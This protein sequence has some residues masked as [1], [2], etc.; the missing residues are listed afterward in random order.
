MK[1]AYCGQ[2]LARK[3]TVLHRRSRLAPMA[4]SFTVALASPSGCMGAIGNSAASV[5]G[6]WL[7]GGLLGMGADTLIGVDE[8]RRLAFDNI[9][10]SRVVRG[11]CG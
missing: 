4:T 9:A 11:R 2:L 5:P 7:A 1:A 10:Q 8:D 6:S 3:K